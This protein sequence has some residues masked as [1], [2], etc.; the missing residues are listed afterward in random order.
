MSSTFNIAGQQVGR[1]AYGLM[2]LTLT[3]TPPSDEDAFAAMKTAVDNGSN[4]WSS[5]AF[6]GPPT[7]PFA[8]IKL[9][10]RFFDKYPEYKTKV[11]LVIKGGVVFTATGPV[12]VG[13]DL[14]YLRKELKTFKDILGDKAVD[15]FSLAR[16][17]NPPVEDIFKGLVTLQNEGWFNAIAGSEM[18]A[19]SLERASKITPIVLNEIEVSLMSYE[20]SIRAAIAWSE[21]NKVPF[22]AYSPLGRGLLTRTFTTPDHAPGSAGAHTPRLQG[23]AFYQNMKLVDLVDEIAEKKGVKSG[24]LALAWSMPLPGTTKP[25]RVIENINAANIKL[26]AEE[27][28][29]LQHI[30]DTFEVK[31]PRYIEAALPDLMK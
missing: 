19:A 15:V 5:A 11:V 3:A 6:Y 24:E 29:A 7:D 25:E 31:G 1:M 16:L 4:C 8:N 9:L 10:R 2:Q 20:P 27:L 22:F 14:D 21:A 18:S 26:T 13:D 30:V 12:A 28:G 17:P 23:D